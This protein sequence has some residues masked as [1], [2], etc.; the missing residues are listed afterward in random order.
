M[1]GEE[2]LSCFFEFREVIFFSRYLESPVKDLAPLTHNIVCCVRYRDPKY[3]RGFIFPARR[4]KGAKEPPRVLKPSD[5]APEQNRNWRAQI[6]MAP[7]TQ[8][9]VEKQCEIFSIYLE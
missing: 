3:A 1:A 9:L 5:L 2:Y 6:G 7:A 4:L 8:R